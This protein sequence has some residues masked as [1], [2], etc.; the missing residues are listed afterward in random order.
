MSSSGSGESGGGAGGEVGM[1]LDHQVQRDD[2]R[3]GLAQQRDDQLSRA[4]A[5]VRRG[6]FP[7]R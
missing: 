4:R 3:V 2:V 5:V 6:G 1:V 7:I